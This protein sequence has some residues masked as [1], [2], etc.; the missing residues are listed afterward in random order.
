MIKMRRRLQTDRTYFCTFFRACP[1]C[2]V[3][4]MWCAVFRYVVCGVRYVV[5]GMW[6]V[7]CGVRCAVCG[8]GICAVCM[9]VQLWCPFRSQFCTLIY[10]KA[11]T[12]TVLSEDIRQSDS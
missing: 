12:Y 1:Q 8:A 4:G 5:C 6:Y 11:I 3:C 10:V 9:S 7:V 2:A